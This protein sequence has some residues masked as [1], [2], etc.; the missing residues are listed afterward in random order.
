MR[1]RVVKYDVW[2][3]AKD[4]WEVNDKFATSVYVE[5]DGDESDY[6]INRRLS[7]QGITWEGEEGTLY[8]SL[9]NGKPVMELWRE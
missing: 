4:G 5:L 2:G 1:Y 8:G 9:Q 7:V 3:N 6:T